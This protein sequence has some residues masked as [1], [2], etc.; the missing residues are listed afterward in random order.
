MELGAIFLIICVIIIV[1][2]FVAQPFTR[3]WRVKAQSSHEISTLLAERERALNALMELDFDNGIGKIPV[4]EYTSQRASLIQ[5]GSDILHQLDEIQ[6]AQHLPTEMYIEP[7]VP[8]KKVKLPSD[9]DL[10]DLIAKRRARRSQKTAGFCPNCGK[11][12]LLSDHFCPSCG[13]IV[14]SK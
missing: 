11:P 5:R 8:E 9:E 4:E 13:Q 7:A 14:N 1:G 10:E 6:G 12:I 3:N 2:L